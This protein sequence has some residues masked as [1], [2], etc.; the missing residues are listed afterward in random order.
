MTSLVLP[1]H[2]CIKPSSLSSS[3]ANRVPQ[4]LLSLPPLSL[5]DC[6]VAESAMSAGTQ[7]GPGP[8][9]LPALSESNTPGAPHS[10]APSLRS[11]AGG[12]QGLQLVYVFTTHLANM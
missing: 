6:H 7:L 9:P 5:A 8:N 2:A 3:P 11:D 1:L 10:A 12:K 4:R